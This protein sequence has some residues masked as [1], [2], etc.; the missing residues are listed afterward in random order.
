M[1]H[2]KSSSLKVC[3]H[4]SIEPKATPYE[5]F[6]DN[7][8]KEE[9]VLE[10]IG[11]KD[12]NGC[13]SRD[14]QGDKVSSKKSSSSMEIFNEDSD[15]DEDEVFL[16]NDGNSFPSSSGGGGQTLEEDMLNAYDDYE[17][18]FEEYPSSY[19]EFCDQF[20]FK[21]KGLGRKQLFSDFI[22]TG[23]P[24]WQLAAYEVGLRMVMGLEWSEV[25]FE[26]ESD[27]GD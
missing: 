2:P 25:V 22:R 9:S 19:Q 14:K 24:R 5:T 12:I 13:T 17:D 21:V 16:P 8:A 3:K 20:D 26:G 1:E 7:S 11:N 18:Q 15:T 10:F 23:L 27:R 6:V 4:E